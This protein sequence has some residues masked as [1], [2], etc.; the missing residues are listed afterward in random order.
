MTHPGIQDSICVSRKQTSNRRA[1]TS[2]DRAHSPTDGA[3]AT[4][5]MHIRRF[6]NWHA[7]LNPGLS[8]TMYRPVADNYCVG[9]R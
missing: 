1:A 8:P 2:S 6:E 4:R 9:K 3:H 7:S 5:S